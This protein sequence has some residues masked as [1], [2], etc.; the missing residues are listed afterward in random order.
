MQDDDFQRAPG[1]AFPLRP[2]PAASPIALF[3]GALPPRAST[4][5]EPPVEDDADVR[6]SLER[7]PKVLVEERPRPVD[8]DDGA[9]ARPCLPA[10]SIRTPAAQ[11]VAQSPVLEWKDDA[12]QDAAP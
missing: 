8:H 4:L 10:H 11:A 2:W 5:R 1:L 3:G 9:H 7:E 6:H 12:H